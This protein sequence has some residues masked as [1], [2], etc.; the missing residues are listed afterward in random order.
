MCT[1]DLRLSTIFLIYRNLLRL[2]FFIS[3]YLHCEIKTGNTFLVI[4]NNKHAIRDGFRGRKGRSLNSPSLQEDQY[5]SWRPILIFSLESDSNL[6]SKT[7]SFSK[8]TSFFL[9]TSKTSFFLNIKNKFF[10]MLVY[11]FFVKQTRFF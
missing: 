10:L 9:M 4:G 5:T 1:T 11:V 3:Y 6:F 2:F 7:S 8:K